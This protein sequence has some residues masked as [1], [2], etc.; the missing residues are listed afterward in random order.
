MAKREMY[1]GFDSNEFIGNLNENK[2]QTTLNV[3]FMSA[4]SVEYARK[5]FEEINP[6]IKWCVFKKSVLERGI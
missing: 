3:Q 5:G 4:T 6:A 2:T 1:V